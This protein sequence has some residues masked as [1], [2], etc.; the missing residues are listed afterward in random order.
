[1]EIKEKANV[2]P[3]YQSRWT[4]T[5]SRVIELRG[6]GSKKSIKDTSNTVKDQRMQALNNEKDFVV[7]LDGIMIPIMDK[8]IG[9]RSNLRIVSITGMGGIG[10]STLAKTIYNNSLIMESFQVRGWLMVSQEVNLQKSS[11]G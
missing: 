4:R 10:K 9:K 6:R 1:M 11:S 3:R 2:V 8:L 5:W 7:G